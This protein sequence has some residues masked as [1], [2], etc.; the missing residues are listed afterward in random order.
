MEAQGKKRTITFDPTSRNDGKNTCNL[1]SVVEI[2]VVVDEKGNATDNTFITE[3]VIKVYNE[4]LQK[5]K[6]MKQEYDDL[7]EFISNE[8]SAIETPENLTEFMT[9]I[10]SLKHV[11]SSLLKAKEMLTKKAAEINVKFNKEKA[12]YETI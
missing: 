6:E 11:G 7:I 2:P 5:N 12:C 3:K 1:P 10:P 4:R 9:K 8:L